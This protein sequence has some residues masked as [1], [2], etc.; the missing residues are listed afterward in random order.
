MLGALK[1]HGLDN[2]TLVMFSSDNGPWYQGSPG[3][4][5]GRKGS[6][7]EG[8]V[9]EPFLARFPGRIPRGSLSAGVAGTIDILPTVARLCG[10]EAPAKPLDGID[11]W[12]L[13]TGRA[14][15][16]E[17]EALLYFDN[18]NVQ[19]A[20]WGQWKQHFARYNTFAY[21]PAPAGGRVNLILPQPELYN[22]EKDP[23]ESYDAAPENPAVVGEIQARVERLIAGFPEEARKAWAETKARAAQPGAVGS[24]PR[25][26]KQP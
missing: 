13:L 18:W 4:L 16:I 15:Q 26:T 1:K 7:Y 19:C 12:S 17:R 3:R 5:R 14:R 6:T 24:L 25:P 8:G 21:S 2:N 11:I 10:A 9:R 22:L 20:R 23:D